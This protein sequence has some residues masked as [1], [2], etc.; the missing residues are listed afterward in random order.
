LA[1]GCVL[2][3]ILLILQLQVTLTSANNNLFSD[4]VDEVEEEEEEEDHD[5]VDDD[6]A[7]KNKNKKNKKYRSL[8][9]MEM[10]A[11]SE[12]I[13]DRL[14]NQSGRAK[15]AASL[16]KNPRSEARRNGTSTDD[17]PEGNEGGGGVHV[18]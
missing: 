4:N 12:L 17:M 8:A 11:I 16:K 10:A 2:R 18:M 9:E 6:V 1:L 7:S 14:A 15:L 5:G 3:H 13:Q